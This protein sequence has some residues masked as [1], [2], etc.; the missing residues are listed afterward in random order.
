MSTFASDKAGI[1]SRL[2]AARAALAASYREEASAEISRLLLTLPE[3][4]A[5][6][7]LLAYAAFGSEASVDAA[8]RVLI[9]RGVGVLLPWVDGPDL[10]LARVRDLDADLAPGWRGVREPRATTRRPARP[11]RVQAALVPGVGFDLHGGRLGYGGG[12]FDRL[13]AHLR[14]DTP[15]VGVAFATQ[16][17]ER[18]PVLPHDIPVD[19]LVTE[20]GVHR[21]ASDRRLP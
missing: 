2:L 3:V 12:H 20:D 4:A 1:R 17:V 19:V 18:I 10:H 9:D 21:P 13:L 14:H 5:A 15:R 7:A 16:I 8:L 11:D 6:R